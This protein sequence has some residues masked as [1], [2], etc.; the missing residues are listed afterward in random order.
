M[1]AMKHVH[2]SQ[3]LMFYYGTEYAEKLGLIQYII[4]AHD[5][6]TSNWIRF[7]N[8]SRNEQEENVMVMD[9]AGR[10]TQVDVLPGQELM[11]HYRYYYAPILG[12]EYLQ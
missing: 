1:M 2:P 11:F 4:D 3:E 9:C 12:I 5:I 6:K 7:I 10:M 8:C